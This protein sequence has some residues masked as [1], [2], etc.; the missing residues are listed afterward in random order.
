[1]SRNV[2][3]GPDRADRA[4]NAKSPRNGGRSGNKEKARTRRALCQ[5]II[6]TKSR[7]KKP[8][9]LINSCAFILSPHAFKHSGGGGASGGRS[10][11]SLAMV[12]DKHIWHAL[13]FS[14]RAAACAAR[15]A[16]GALARRLLKFF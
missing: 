10:N 4:R 12:N 9:M 7:V 8:A 13:A 6:V 14:A 15:R 2:Q 11:A 16:G 1:M 3:T 5:I